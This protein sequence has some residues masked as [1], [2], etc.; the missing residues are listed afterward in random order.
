MHRTASGAHDRLFFSPRGRDAL[1]AHPDSSTPW[2]QFTTTM[3][4]GHELG[5]DV[6]DVHRLRRLS[7]VS[8]RYTEPP[9][10]KRSPLVTFFHWYTSWAIPGLGMF[11]EAYIIFSLGLTRPLQAVV[12]P[13]CFVTHAACTAD[14]THVQN[15]IQIAGIAVGMAALPVRLAAAPAAACCC[16]LLAVS[17]TPRTPTPTTRQPIIC[18]WAYIRLMMCAA[19]LAHLPTPPCVLYARYAGVWR[20]G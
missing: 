6:A 19:P 1:H 5:V 13:E 20:A 3:P 11:S 17:T 18:G 7:S 9:K 12:H 10:R 15:Y 2:P 4:T 16:V 8:R 14:L